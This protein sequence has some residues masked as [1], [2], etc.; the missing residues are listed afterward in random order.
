MSRAGGRSVM[1]SSKG[2]TTT[3]GSGST[4]LNTNSNSYVHFPTGHE[5]LVHDVAYGR[6]PALRQRACPESHHPRIDY[7][8]RRMATVSSDQRLKIFDLS[9]GN[10]WVQSDSFKAHDASINK[11]RAHLSPFTPPPK[12]AN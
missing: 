7:Y 8:G 6:C 4:V 12:N 3:V 11:V 9:E 10:E 2:T 1:S 5:D